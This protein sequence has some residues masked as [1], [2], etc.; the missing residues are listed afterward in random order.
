MPSQSVGHCHT[1]NF[2]QDISKPDL[3]YYWPVSRLPKKKNIQQET[4]DY[5]FDFDDGDNGVDVGRQK[6]QAA[7][8]YEDDEEEEEEE[9]EEEIIDDL[10]VSS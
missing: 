9:D 5:D 1:Y 7:S 6:G 10:T 8:L 3:L 4:D 2:F